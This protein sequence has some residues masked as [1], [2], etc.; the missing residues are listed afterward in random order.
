MNFQQQRLRIVKQQECAIDCGEV[1]DQDEAPTPPSTK[2]N[3]IQDLQEVKGDS[4]HNSSKHYF[5]SKYFKC[6]NEASAGLC[7]SYTILLSHFEQCDKIGECTTCKAIRTS[8]LKQYYQATTRSKVE[9]GTD[10]PDGTHMPSPAL[11]SSEKGFEAKNTEE[12][13]VPLK[14]RRLIMYV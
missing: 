10:N 14:K 11:A 8:I 12:S 9:P 2:S 1:T 4:F 7:L 13:S 5:F 3:S 6:C